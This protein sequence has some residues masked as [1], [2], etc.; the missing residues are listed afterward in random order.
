MIQHYYENLNLDDENIN[1]TSFLFDRGSLQR[2][3]EGGKIGE[4]GGGVNEVGICR[5]GLVYFLCE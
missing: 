3:G 2:E 5:P 1:D 4:M